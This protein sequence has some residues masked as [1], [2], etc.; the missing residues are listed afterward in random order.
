MRGANLGNYLEAPAGATWGASYAAADFANIKREGFDHVRL[1]I[2]WNDYAGPAPGFKLSG[3]IFAKADFLTTNALRNQLSVIVNI[4]HFDE[5]TDNPSAQSNKFIALWR[6]IAAHYSSGPDSLAFEI[7]NEP[8]DAATTTVMNPIYAGVIRE[9][10]RTNPTRA[11]FVGP[12]RW[13]QANELKDLQLPA[14]DQNLIV[15]IHCYEPF[16]FTH[17]GATWSGP[18]TKVRGIQFPGPPSTPL[19]PD[20]SLQISKGVSNWIYRYNTLSGDKNPSS[21]EAFRKVIRIAREWSNQHKRPIHMGEFGCYIQAD[22]ESRTRF[23]AEFR[24]ALDEAQMGWAIWDWKAGFRYW[25]DRKGEPVPG[26][27]EALFGGKAR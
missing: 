27:H 11:I 17:Q 26:M 9:I 10:R 14:D 20:P 23:Y 25:D 15:T 6:Q 12:G 19:T 1:P 24:K 8:K 2:R 16:F 7:L 22:A 3:E 18:D 21:P 4:H 13:N 5:F